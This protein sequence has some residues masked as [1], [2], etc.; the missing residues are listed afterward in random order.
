MHG[1]EHGR[2]GARACFDLCPLNLNLRAG[3]TES[4]SKVS[5]RKGMT[6]VEGV[7]V[8]KLDS[9]YTRATLAVLEDI[10]AYTSVDVYDKVRMSAF[11]V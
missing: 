1:W 7:P 10:E 8:A 6:I 4:Y 3:S 9:E 11:V 5:E 2:Y